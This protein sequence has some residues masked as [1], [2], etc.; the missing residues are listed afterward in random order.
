MARQA[1]LHKKAETRKLE[2]KLAR[3]GLPL[4]SGPPPLTL[5]IAVAERIAEALASDPQR[6]SR[7]FDRLWHAAV[8]EFT[9][10]LS[11]AAIALAYADWL[12][13]LGMSP[14]RQME[15][16]QQGGQRWI[17]W[18]IGAFQYRIGKKGACYPVD[19]RFHE[20]YQHAGWQC[21]PYNLLATAHLSA[22]EWWEEASQIYGMTPH[23][24]RMI[25]FLLLLA[26]QALSPENS[27]SLNPEMQEKIRAEC[28]MNFLKGALNFM[29]DTQ[30]WWKNGI[31]PGTE[32]FMP[33]ENVAV[34]EGKV[35]FRNALFELIQYSPKTSKTF[36]EPVMIIPAW[37]M[38]YYILDL[39]PENSMVKYLVEQGHTVFMIS[40][41]NP[42]ARY[43][44]VSFIDYMREGAL[45]ALDV[46]QEIIPGRQVHAVGYCIGGTLLAM[47]AAYLAN[48][49]RDIL[50]TITLFAAQ[51]D[52]TEAG[53]LMTFIDESQVTYLED[54]M[55]IQGY[56]RGDQI[57]AAF[58]LLKPQ[59]L[60]WSRILKEY[61]MGEREKSFDLMAWDKDTTRLP[62]RMH[63]DYLHTLYLKNALATGGFDIDDEMLNLSLITSPM[64]V[65]STEKDHIAP[66]KSVYKIHHLTNGDLTFVLTNKG[67]NGGIISEP[68]HRD[69]EYRIATHHPGEHP[70]HAE[71]WKEAVKPV[72]GSWWV[73]WHEWLAARSTP[74]AA[75]PVMGGGKYQPLADAPGQYVHER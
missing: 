50:Q 5:E 2:E 25:K 32:E 17:E 7:I 46:V 58:D 53:Q 15:M 35:V 1:A 52:F 67:H 27:P 69:R 3:G 12:I 10:G 63:S 4:P 30:R 43:R 62:Y 9:T 65:V 68:G 19:T 72:P 59:E 13:H 16:L 29:E 38:K 61:V 36:P 64:F 73:R 33:G 71:K 56:L 45:Q 34:T 57:S 40:W 8:G 28:G 49:R 51:V 14:N 75:P 21:W 55:F 20:R 11:P 48:T 42:D 47:L 6:R 44:E 22:E 41:K 39:S 37:I 60:I 54:I 18:A 70:L 24:K 66:W 74:L 23:H 31:P 26:L